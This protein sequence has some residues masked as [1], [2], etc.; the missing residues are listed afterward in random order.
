MSKFQTALGITGLVLLSLNSAE[1][2]PK[3]RD[4]YPNFKPLPLVAQRQPSI[5]IECILI[6]PEKIDVNYYHY[7]S[8]FLEK[9]E[10]VSTTYH[11]EIDITRIIE[12]S[13][14]PDCDKINILNRLR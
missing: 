1:S 2:L 8:G 14:L 6:S 5:P 9:I 7:P 11:P 13:E 3:N 4:I 10:S 12:L